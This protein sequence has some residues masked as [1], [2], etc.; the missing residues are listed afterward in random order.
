MNLKI[1]RANKQTNKQPNKCLQ[2][3]MIP[4]YWIWKAEECYLPC[5][6]YL[7]N[8]LT[9]CLSL[10]SLLMHLFS[11]L[12]LEWIANLLLYA[13]I[14][15]SL[16]WYVKLIYLI[17]IILVVK[18]LPLVFPD[19]IRS[20]FLF[21]K[22]WWTGTMQRNSFFSLPWLVIILDQMYFYTFN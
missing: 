2:S 11:F 7:I 8:S 16:V 12:K 5:T 13:N 18:L 14:W 4:C 10:Y 3:H 6:I 17:L 19:K 20:Y 9:L 1:C 21:G 15:I 22:V